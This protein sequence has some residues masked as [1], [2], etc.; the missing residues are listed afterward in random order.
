MDCPLNERELYAK[1]SKTVSNAHELMVFECFLLFNKHVLKTNFYQPTKVALSFRLDPGF[2]PESEYPNKLFG[3]FFVIGNEF[4]GFHLRFR[5][6]ARGGI[7]IIRSRNREAY[8]MNQRYLFDENYNL[9]S[10]QQRK[11]KDIPEGGSKGTILLDMNCQDKP[12][13]AF[14]KYV[15]SILDLL[16]S[17]CSPGIKEVFYYIK[18]RRLSIYME[19]LRYYFLAQMR[20]PLIIWIG[21][22]CMRRNV[23]HPFGRPLQLVKARVWVAFLMIFTE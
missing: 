13:V 11:N 21:P 22:V 7:R 18:F 5:D 9:A 2:L 23:E 16:I 3:M 8:S 20:E 19:N 10:T 12:K 6:V 4:R 15:D 17:G 14:D 1:I